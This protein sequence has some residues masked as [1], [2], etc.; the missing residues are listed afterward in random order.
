VGRGV[1]DEFGG[2][3]C[4]TFQAAIGVADSDRL[5]VAALE[6]V[7]GHQIV[8]TDDKVQVTWRNNGTLVF[9][10]LRDA[11]PA[12]RW[13]LQVT[14]EA[15]THEEINKLDRQSRDP[16]GAATGIPDAWMTNESATAQTWE[17]FNCRVWEVLPVRA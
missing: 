12:R 15:L 17:L 7:C 10:L 16:A 5:R 1:V 9:L 6:L 13:L 4:D 14:I 11:N 3:A 2:S 8:S